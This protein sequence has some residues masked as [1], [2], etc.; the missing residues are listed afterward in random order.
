[1][2]AALE[3]ELLRRFMSDIPKDRYEE[4]VEK[5]IHRNLS[6][7]EAVRMLFDGSLG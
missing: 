4:I 3:E 6:P 5:V 1:L 2:E 7:Y